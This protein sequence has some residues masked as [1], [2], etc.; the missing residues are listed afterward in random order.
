MIEVSKNPSNENIRGI[1]KN[2]DQIEKA[3]TNLTRMGMNPGVVVQQDFLEWS[4]TGDFQPNKILIDAPCSGLGILRKYPEGKLHKKPNLIP[5]MA[6]IQRLL[7]E[8]GVRSL[9][10]GGRMV[11]SVC[12]FEPEELFD[13][14]VWIK[15]EFADEV[16]VLS[17]LPHLP[18][19]YKKYVTKQNI[20]FVMC[21]NQ[22]KMDGFSAFILQKN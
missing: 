1:D 12:S 4:A 17:P 9:P 21:G 13:H 5:Q 3:K 19:Y 7:I 11:Y 15:K 6:K 14:L 10:K 20:F 18:N 22:D 2:L 16:S 8:H